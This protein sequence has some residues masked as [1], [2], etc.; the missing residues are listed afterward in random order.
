MTTK[1]NCGKE[2]KLS[3]SNR[4]TVY[5]GVKCQWCTKV[6]MMMGNLGLEF[7]V[8]SVKGNKE[9]LSFMHK[10]GLH[11]VPQVFE[12]DRLIGGYEATKEHL[13]AMKEEQQ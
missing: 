1:Q 10:M 5:T 6:I 2:Q 9:A 13:L 3:K 8:V 4:Y 11:T 7:D 12:G